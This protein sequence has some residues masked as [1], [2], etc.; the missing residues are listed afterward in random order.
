MPTLQDAAAQRYATLAAGLLRVSRAGALFPD[1]AALATFVDFL[2][3]PSPKRGLVRVEVDPSTGLPP[4]RALRRLAMLRQ[5]AVDWL[6]AHGARPTPLA[7]AYYVVLAGTALPPPSAVW[8]RLV[9]R[10]RKGSRFLVVQDRYAG[11]AG[12]PSRVTVQ[13]RDARGLHVELDR[14]DQARVLPPLVRALEAGAAQGAEEL[15]LTLGTLE[16]VEV[17]EVVRTALG[18]LVGGPTAPAPDPADRSAGLGAVL[19][20]VAPAERAAEGALHLVLERAGRTVSQDRDADPWAGSPP[21]AEALR[22]R[23]V[24][25]YRVSRERRLV[26]TP[27]LEAGL[28]AQVARLGAPVVVRSR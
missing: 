14:G 19:A 23:Q 24:L 25:G 12:G 15:L 8:A 1:A 22:R 2:A 13:L 16:G 11:R 27:A 20:A 5:V 3:R 6:Q 17:D 9:T 28:K 18:P 7:R 10:E 21:G 26:C 4:L